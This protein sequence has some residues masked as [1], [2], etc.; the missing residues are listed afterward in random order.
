MTLIGYL[1]KFS[2]SKNS[3]KIR[4]T[5]LAKKP[6]FPLFMTLL[7]LLFALLKVGPKLFINW[8]FKTSQSRDCAN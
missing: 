6:T 1:A 5:E 3:D 4:L 2:L 7:R 8:C